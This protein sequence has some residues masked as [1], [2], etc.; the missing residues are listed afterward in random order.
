MHYYKRHSIYAYFVQKNSTITGKYTLVYRTSETKY[1]LWMCL[2][3]LHCNV[4][5]NNVTLN[6]A[7][8]NKGTFNN[9]IVNKITVNNITVSEVTGNNVTVNNVIVNNALNNVLNSE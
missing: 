1:S 4:T 9:I 3:T 6:K 8:V 2:E 7:T 5:V